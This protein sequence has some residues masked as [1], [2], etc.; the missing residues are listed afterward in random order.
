M[1]DED[2][3]QD[4]E[5]ARPQRVEVER[6]APHEEEAAHRVGDASRRRR[7]NSMRAAVVVDRDAIARIQPKLPASPSSQ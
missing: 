7:G 3:E 6:V 1:P 2:L 5:P 4:L